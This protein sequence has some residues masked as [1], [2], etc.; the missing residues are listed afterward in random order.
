MFIITAL[1][2]NGRTWPRS[3]NGPGAAASAKEATDSLLSWAVDLIIAKM[4]L[5]I[6]TPHAQKPHYFLS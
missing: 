3:E 6:L 4:R 2:Y 5:I 1:A